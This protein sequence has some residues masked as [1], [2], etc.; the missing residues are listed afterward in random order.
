VKL[1]CHT[2]ASTMTHCRKKMSQLAT[3]ARSRPVATSC[4][5]EFRLLFGSKKQNCF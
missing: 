3:T 2:T 1:Q 5:H 4:T